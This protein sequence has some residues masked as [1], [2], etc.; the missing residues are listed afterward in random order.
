[1][2]FE[3]LEHEANKQLRLRQLIVE[4][5]SRKRY[6]HFNKIV[7]LGPRIQQDYG[8]PGSEISFN[9]LL[10]ELTEAIIVGN[11]SLFISGVMSWDEYES[12]LGAIK[13][14]IE[15]FLEERIEKEI[16]QYY[17]LNFNVHVKMTQRNER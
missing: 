17:N 3:Q 15:N 11:Q 8:V 4:R 7:H 5:Y 16:Y 2:D 13:N 6:S 10:I 12:V 14:A 1:M 9:K